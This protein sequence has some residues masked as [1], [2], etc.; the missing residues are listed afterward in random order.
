MGKRAIKQDIMQD[1]NENKAKKAPEKG[2]YAKHME[3]VIRKSLLKV[4]IQQVLKEYKT[5][6]KWAYILHDK[7]DTAEHYHIYVNFGSASVNSLDVAKWF[8]CRASD[9]EKIKGRSTDMLSYL[10]HGNPSQKHKHQYDP[11]E[12]IANF[13]LSD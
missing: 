7:D 4:D 8:K 10:T 13:R 3:V 9:I 2:F 12:V 6:K 1:F 11:S 5:I